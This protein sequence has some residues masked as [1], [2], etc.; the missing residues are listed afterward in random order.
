MNAILFEI[1]ENQG[2]RKLSFRTVRQAGTSPGWRWFPA[3]ALTEDPKQTEFRSLHCNWIAVQTDEVLH[4]STSAQLGAEPFGPFRNTGSPKR[5][6]PVQQE[7]GRIAAARFVALRYWRQASSLKTPSIEVRRASGRLRSGIS[8]R[9]RSRVFTECSEK[10]VSV[11][12]HPKTEGFMR[13]RENSANILISAEPR[14]VERRCGMGIGRLSYKATQ[15]D[16]YV[17]YSVPRLADKSQLAHPKVRILHC[18][19][20]F[21]PFW[22]SHQTLSPTGEQSGRRRRGA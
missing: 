19:H 5:T 15:P 3:Q 2:E 18:L 4:H 20:P 12:H 7:L 6:A 8:R 10:V 22:K 14:Q 1:V 13:R 16:R 21:W 9:P 11:C 17:R